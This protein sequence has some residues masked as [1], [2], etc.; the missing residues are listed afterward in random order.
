MSLV[1]R[2]ERSRIA[3]LQA[4]DPAV[5]DGVTGPSARASFTTTKEAWD[6]RPA[7]LLRGGIR[8]EPRGGWGLP[9]PRRLGL[10]LT[11][12][13]GVGTTHDIVALDVETTGLG[14]GTVPFI[15]GVL[16]GDAVAKTWTFRQWTLRRMGGEGPMLEDC[17]AY[18]GGRRAFTLLSY[19]GKSFDIPVL[20]GRARRVSVDAFALRGPHVDLLHPARR[21][22][23]SGRGS[24]RLQRLE[25]ARLGVVRVGDIPGAEIPEVFWESL[26]GTDEAL[27]SGR[28]PR[29][30]RHN[31]IDLWSLVRLCEE[32]VGRMGAPAALREALAAAHPRAR[33]SPARVI[34]LLRP[35]TDN[36]P[37][38]RAPA[39]GQRRLLEVAFRRISEAQRKHGDDAGL[40]RTLEA[41]LVVAPGDP[42]ASE[43]LAILR[44]RRFGDL[45]GALRVARSS[46]EPCGRRIARLQRRLRSR[47][48]L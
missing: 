40:A 38:D 8:G 9:D 42:R 35:W 6:R 2:F 1:A 48:L 14:A 33:Q 19:N 47:G 41:W 24:C 18:L 22:W 23:D 17:L 4:Q 27:S 44:E 28:L 43:R 20:R 3:R 45:I 31:A 29:V 39:V 25:R 11:Q 15:I 16:V 26:A 12:T 34:Q 13:L 36:E 37:G 32:V 10:A 21:L 5:V 46:R 30:E 7:Q